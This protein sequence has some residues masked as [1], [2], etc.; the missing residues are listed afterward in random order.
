MLNVA[1]N[2]NLKLN[3]KAFNFSKLK[4]CSDEALTLETLWSF[5]IYSK[6]HLDGLKYVFYLTFNQAIHCNYSYNESKTF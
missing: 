5:Q 4:K 2:I 1:M 3:S 6:V